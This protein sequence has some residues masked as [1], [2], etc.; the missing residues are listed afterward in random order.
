MNPNRREILRDLDA[1]VENLR[2]DA[3]EER[4]ARPQHAALAMRG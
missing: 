1:F 3:V 4:F 2:W